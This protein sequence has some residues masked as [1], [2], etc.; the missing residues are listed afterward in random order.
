MRIRALRGFAGVLTM[1]KGEEREYDNEAVIKDL[2]RAGYIVEVDEDKIPDGSGSPD[3]NSGTV[4]DDG[5]NTASEGD[6][7]ASDKDVKPSAGKR[8]NDKTPG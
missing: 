4:P 2:F 7:T 6:N 3:G 1:S 8:S 5:D